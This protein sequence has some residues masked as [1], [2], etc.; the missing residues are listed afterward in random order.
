MILMQNLNSALGIIHE[1]G[2]AKERSCDMTAAF[3][4]GQHQ[5]YHYPRSFLLCV[6]GN[7][8]VTDS[9]IRTDTN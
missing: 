1:I 8:S 2:D 7:S 4:T 5:R 3:R 6:D 9:M